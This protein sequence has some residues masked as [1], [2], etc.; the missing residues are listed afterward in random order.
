MA[1][2]GAPFWGARQSFLNLTLDAV[3]SR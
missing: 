2:H 1:S 3:Y